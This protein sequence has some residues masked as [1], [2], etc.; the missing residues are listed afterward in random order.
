MY[1]A[2]CLWPLQWN[3]ALMVWIALNK[4]GRWKVQALINKFFICLSVSPLIMGEA[5]KNAVHKK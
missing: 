3:V 1:K 2:L 4:T 5:V